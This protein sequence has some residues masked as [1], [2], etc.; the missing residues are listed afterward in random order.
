MIGECVDCRYFHYEKINGKVKRSFTNTSYVCKVELPQA[1]V[2]WH[3]TLGLRFCSFNRIIFLLCL[4]I[5]CF[6]LVDIAKQKLQF[7]WSNATKGAN[8]DHIFLR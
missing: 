5:R 1:N 8:S 6:H 2:G 4:L 3:W 7:R